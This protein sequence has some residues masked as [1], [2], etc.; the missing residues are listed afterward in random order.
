MFLFKIKA[1]IGRSV[2]GLGYGVALKFKTQ[3]EVYNALA[4]HSDML[5]MPKK[6]YNTT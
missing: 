4:Y 1:P 6:L 2:G 3:L 5:I